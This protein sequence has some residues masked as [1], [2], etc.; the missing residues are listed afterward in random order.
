MPL[1][2]RPHKRVD[3]RLYQYTDGDGGY[4]VRVEGWRPDGTKE[5]THKVDCP[6][7]TSL[8]Q[9]MVLRDEMLAAVADGTYRR[10]A[11]MLDI[12]PRTLR[13]AADAYLDDRR[14]RWSIQSRRT[15]TA[16]RQRWASLDGIRL[17]RLTY[18]EH[19]APLALELEEAGYSVRYRAAIHSR[20]RAVLRF[21]VLLG[22]IPS[23]PAARLRTPM[24]ESRMKVLPDVVELEPMFAHWREHD[25]KREAVGRYVGVET[26]YRLILWGAL[27]QGEARNARWSWIDVDAQVLELPAEIVKTRRGRQV[28]LSLEMLSLL[29]TH[30]ARLE[31]CGRP[32]DDDA[33]IFPSAMHSKVIAAHVVS[34]LWWQ[35]A[36]EAAGLEDLTPHD[37]R[38]IGISRMAEA[39]MSEAVI[40]K[41][42][43][44]R[45]SKM[46]WHYRGVFKSDLQQAAERMPS[47]LPRQSAETTEPAYS[48]GVRGGYKSNN[49]QG[50]SHGE[51][52]ES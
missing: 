44:H 43:G 35:P 51:S 7:G 9:A 17:D 6:P 15:F 20:L 36:L 25:A 10:E 39:G 47:V 2:R 29:A 19:I 18:R 11:Q 22:W 1:T 5:R 3:R 37:L 14:R 46:H 30:R 41:I 28:P 12:T 16:I 24:P 38:R 42:T 49:Q 50:A 21:A 52:D 26:L 45:S 40:L 8:G 4:F 23:S 13:D 31:R 27:R 32:T 34:A 48:V 33:P